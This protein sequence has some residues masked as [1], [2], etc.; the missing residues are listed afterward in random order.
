MSDSRFFQPP[1]GLTIAEIV[2]LTGAQ[3]APGADLT[4]RIGNIA[5][6]DRAAAGD[7]TFMESVKF[8]G[9]QGDAGYRLPDG[10][11]IRG[12]GAGASHRATQRQGAG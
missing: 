6:I 2:A 1:S 3:V 4:Q 5:P 8:A 12:R 9:L 11:A 7:L 10:G